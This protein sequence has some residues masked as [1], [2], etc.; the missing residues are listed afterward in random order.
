MNAP[1]P[2]YANIAVAMIRAQKMWQSVPSVL[3]RYLRDISRRLT[4]EHTGV[5][6]RCF[7][8]IGCGGLLLSNYQAGF[9]DVFEDGHEY[10]CYESKDDLLKK[11]DY[12]LSHEDE[13]AEIARNG[14]NRLVKDHTYD[15]RINEM[16]SLL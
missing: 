6:L 2:K 12:L 9:A 16:L 7:E 5:P 3:C 4:R 10:V 11:I 15:N 14:Y 1:F 8:I 13:R